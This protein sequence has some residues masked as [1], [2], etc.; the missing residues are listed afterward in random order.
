MC[1]IN[2]KGWIEYSK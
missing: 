2:M 1:D